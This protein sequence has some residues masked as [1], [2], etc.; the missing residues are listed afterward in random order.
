[1]VQSLLF[2]IMKTMLEENKLEDF[3]KYVYIDVWANW[4]LS[5]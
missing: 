3:G 4:A 1:M 5:W 2:L